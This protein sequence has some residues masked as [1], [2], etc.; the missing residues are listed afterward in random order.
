MHIKTQ[1]EWEE[2]MARKI[3]DV[4]RSELY[5]SLR[6]M[7]AALSKMPWAADEQI[8]TFATDGET[9][10]FSTEQLLR[11]WKQNPVF[12]NRAYLHSILHCI[13]RHLWLRGSRERVLWDL[14]CDI[15]V[16]RVIDSLNLP[17]LKRPLSWIRQKTEKTLSEEGIVA[18]AAVCRW[19]RTRDK[20]ELET[21]RREYYVDDHR[22]WPQETEL[23]A[24]PSAGEDW[25]KLG[26]RMENEL[27]TH[28]QEAGDG[29][30]LISAQIRAAKSRRSYQDFLRKFCALREELH[31]DP[32]SF[33]LGF[34]TYGLSL[35][36]NLPLIEPLESREEM[37][38]EEFAIVIDTSYS[39]SGE[40]VRAFLRETFTLL[41]KSGVFAQRCR[42]RVLQC[43][44]G[45]RD[46]I[47]I[48]SPEQME[49]LS[50]SF[51]IAGGGGTDFRPAF[52]YLE[53]LRQEGA[54]S[55]LR[56]MLYFTDG[57]GIYP[58]K[59]P[60]WDT[61]FVFVGD[62]T[63]QENESSLPGWAMRLTLDPEELERGVTSRF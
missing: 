34:Y 16:E 11:V 21:L 42:I 46:D 37:R 47:L 4:V 50:N 12:C 59:R 25:Q 35:Y 49:R 28:G 3:L 36:G 40:L 10:F 51:T 17:A 60:P 43:D 45:V 56:G 1:S 2:E 44:D 7:D 53:Q 5:L 52:R 32:D 39:T 26:S 38:I 18:P 8:H 30:E 15:A 29:A 55:H 54:F 31:I 58:T 57:K 41:Q 22:F 19:L 6:Y 20:R 62:R 48:T 23:A 9:L 24:N 63:Q 33:D 14:A 27:E 61:A 13:F